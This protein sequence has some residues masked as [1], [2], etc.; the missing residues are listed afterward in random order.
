[1]H[2]EFFILNERKTQIKNEKPRNC[3]HFHKQ[4]IHYKIENLTKKKKTFYNL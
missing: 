3:I 2:K 1:M 4:I